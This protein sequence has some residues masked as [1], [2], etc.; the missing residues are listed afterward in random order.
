MTE[1]KGDRALFFPFKLCKYRTV[2]ELSIVHILQSSYKKWNPTVCWSEYQTLEKCVVTL[3]PARYHIFN[4]NNRILL[5]PKK[6][7]RYSSVLCP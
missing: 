1:N 3:L 7:S 2:I 4:E 6:L 5:Q